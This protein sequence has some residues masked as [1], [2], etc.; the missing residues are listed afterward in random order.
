MFILKLAQGNSSIHSIR[1]QQYEREI[2]FYGENQYALVL[3]A[4]YGGKGYTTHNSIEQLAKIA[5]KNKGYS[6]DII[7]REGNRYDIQKVWTDDYELVPLHCKVSLS[8]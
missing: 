7:D 2:R 6:F 1:N 3:A 8:N 4:Y 5:K